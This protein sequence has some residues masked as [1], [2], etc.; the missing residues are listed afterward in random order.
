LKLI[1][2]IME[3]NDLRNIPAFP[4]PEGFRLRS[5]READTD[6]WADIETSVNEFPNKAQARHHFEDEFGSRLADM[7]DRCLFLLNPSGNAVATT[8]AWFNPDYR[9][10]NYGRI[11]WVAVR[12]EYQGKGLGKVVLGAALERLARWHERAYLTTQTISWVA[13]HMYLNFDFLPVL[14]NRDDR[15]GWQLLNELHPHPMLEPDRYIRR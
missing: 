4:P 12:P 6:L 5:F 9:G 3:R 15:E 11:H 1:H 8:T 14:R 10:Q 7:R 2:L 13:I